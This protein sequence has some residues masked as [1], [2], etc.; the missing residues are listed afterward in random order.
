MPPL[1]FLDEDQPVRSDHRSRHAG[2]LSFHGFREELSLASSYDGPEIVAAISTRPD[3]TQK[4]GRD[5]RR[6]KRAALSHC[7]T[8]RRRQKKMKRNHA[9]NGVARQSDENRPLHA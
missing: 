8:E 3:I 2:T 6:K 9:G 4:P 5:E 1:A 7:F